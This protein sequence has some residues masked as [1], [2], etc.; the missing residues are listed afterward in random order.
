MKH[1]NKISFQKN[2]ENNFDLENVRS[3]SFS[4]GTW[5]VP[6]YVSYCYTLYTSRARDQKGLQRVS[7]KLLSLFPHGR[8]IE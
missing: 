5:K 6:Q 3:Q 2:F 7:S 8:V 4:I 1:V